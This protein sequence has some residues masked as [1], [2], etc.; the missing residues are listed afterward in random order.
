MLGTRLSVGWILAALILGCGVGGTPAPGVDDSY[1]APT[2][3]E[4]AKFDDLTQSMPAFSAEYDVQAPDIGSAVFRWSRS[5]DGMLRWDFAE[6]TDRGA[7]GETGLAPLAVQQFGFVGPD[8][9]PSYGCI[10][11]LR[12]GRANARCRR[13]EFVS[14]DIGGS[15]GAVLAPTDIIGYAERVLGGDVVRCFEVTARHSQGDICFDDA[16]VPRVVR[17]T[18]ERQGTWTYS[19]R[20]VLLAPS[21]SEI[22]RSIIAGVDYPAEATVVDGNEDALDLPLRDLIRD[23]RLKSDDGNN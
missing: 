10:W 15:I 13:S 1:R 4:R 19:L 16:G 21:Q 12:E 20:A 23:W 8:A 5:G 6:L 3:A 9:P 17:S 22:R 14:S 7:S 11:S 2:G 18:I